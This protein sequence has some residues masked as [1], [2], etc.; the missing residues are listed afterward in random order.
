MNGKR[1]H[2]HH[3]TP[4]AKAQKAK[5]KRTYTPKSERDLAKLRN[6]NETF[7]EIGESLSGLADALSKRPR[8]NPFV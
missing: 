2:R 7:K 5:Q 3:G 1:K 8:E 4:K 6:L